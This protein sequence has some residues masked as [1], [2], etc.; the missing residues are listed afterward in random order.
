MKR[1]NEINTSEISEHIKAA[2]NRLL[3][4]HARLVATFEQ[5][6][7]GITCLECGGQWTVADAEG[8]D[9]RHGLDLTPTNNG[10]GYCEEGATSYF[11]S[12]GVVT[13]RL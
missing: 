8:T 9:S 6:R 4:H 2:A 13:H 12:H 10:D 1:S 3:G 5:G 7:V 11:D